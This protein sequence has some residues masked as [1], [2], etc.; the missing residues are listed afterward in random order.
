MEDSYRT[1]EIVKPHWC[2]KMREKRGGRDQGTRYEQRFLKKIRN[3]SDTICEC[4][5]N[6]AVWLIMKL[7]FCEMA[8]SK[9]LCDVCMS[10]LYERCR[11]HQIIR[12]Y[13]GEIKGVTVAVEHKYCTVAYKKSTITKPEY[14]K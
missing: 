6:S 4:C 7:R 8:I 3:S 13:N 12:T 10:E 14:Y 1:R 2:R 11:S 5:N 9:R